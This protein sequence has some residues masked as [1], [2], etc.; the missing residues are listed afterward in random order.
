MTNHTTP[1]TTAHRINR[2][3]EIRRTSR[4]LGYILDLPQGY[5][6][7]DIDQAASELSSIIE[8]Y[9]Y[10]EIELSDVLEG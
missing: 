4:Q 7:H 3:R 6:N 9:N 10:H 2:L 8:D 5:N 1:D